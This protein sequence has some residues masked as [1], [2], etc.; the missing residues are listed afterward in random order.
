MRPMDSE[1]INLAPARDL[2]LHRGLSANLVGFGRLLR[3]RGALPGPGE[4]CD[5]LSALERIDLKD[6]QEFYLALRTTLAKS[7]E[8]QEIFDQHF[9]S[10]WQVW[11]RAL[12]SN[13]AATSDRMEESD[14][15]GDR[16]QPGRPASVT[17]SDWLKGN[18]SAKEEREV[19]GYSPVEVVT[20]RDFSAFGTTEIDEMGRLVAALSKILATRLSRRY[21]HSHRRGSLDLCRTLRLNLPRGGDLLDLSFRR[22]K[23]QKLKL[24]LLCDMSKSMDLYGRFL[25]QFIYSFQNV[26]RRLE[27]FVFS[28]SLHRITSTLKSGDLPEVMSALSSEVPDWSGGT[29]IGAS[30]H[31]FLTRYGM[32]MVDRNTVVLILSDGWDTGDID[33][34]EDSMRGIQKRCRCL[35]WLNPLMGHPGYQPSCRGMQAAL[36]F[37]DIF[38]PAHNLAS[39]RQLAHR[40][41]KIQGQI[42]FSRS[43]H[44][45]GPSAA[46]DRIDSPTS[47]ATAAPKTAFERFGISR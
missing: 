4:F 35:V 38:A 30:L 18:G 12:G 40:L 34:L 37:I 47:A 2:A 17:I 24:V 33:L 7:R 45:V 44:R 11:D 32:D 39:L 16:R 27:T 15:G 3:R 46:T 42:G 36:P 43:I 31:D 22:R 29:R 20:R 9:D 13:R 14:G 25:I 8:E 28:T 5:A 21:R 41:G 23:R 6:S 1:R 19:A 10:Y 26:Y